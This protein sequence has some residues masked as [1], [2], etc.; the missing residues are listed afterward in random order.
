MQLFG[1]SIIIKDF[2]GDYWFRSTNYFL[3]KILRNLKRVAIN[4]LLCQP[5]NFVHVS[6]RLDS[7]ANPRGSVNVLVCDRI[8]ASSSKLLAI[9]ARHKTRKS[10]SSN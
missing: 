6:A 1:M 10:S 2:L 7:R 5:V 4:Q 3:G 9:N 8:R